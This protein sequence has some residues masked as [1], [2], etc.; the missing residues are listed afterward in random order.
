[1]RVIILIILLLALISNVE[2]LAVVSDYLE[3]STLEVIEETSTIYSIRLQNPES[4]EVKVKVDYNDEYMKAIDLKEEYTLD[5]KS[6]TRIEFNVTAPKYNKKNNEFTVG[7]T[8]HQLSG[9]G[10]GIGLLPK[11]NK[12][13]KLRVTKDP[14]KFYIEDYY[15]YIPHAAIILLVIYFLLRKELSSKK[16]RN[17]KIIK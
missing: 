4:Y 15:K 6:S 5:P 11:I 3:K 16:F 2:A 1:M 8:I 14:N 10:G 7:Y 13:F 17:R 12:Q 9:G